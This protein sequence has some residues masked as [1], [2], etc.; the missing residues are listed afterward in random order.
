VLPTDTVYGVGARRRLGRGRAA[1][2]GR[3]A[4]RPR[5]PAAGAR[6]RG[7]RWC[8][9][10][11][12]ASTSASTRS[13]RGL[14]ARAADPRAAARETLRMDLGERG[15]HHRG[16]GPRPRLHPRAAAP[17]R[18][19]GGEQRQRARA[20]RRAHDRRTPSPSWGTRAPSTWTRG[21]DGGPGA[22][23]DRRPDR[24]LGPASC[25]RAGSPSAQLNEAVP[26]LLEIPDP[27]HRRGRVHRAEAGR[28]RCHRPETV[29]RSRTRASGRPARRRRVGPRSRGS[30]SRAEPVREYLLVLL[31]AAGV[32]YVGAS[33]ARR[34]AFRS[35]RSRSCAT[36]T[37]TPTPIPYF[38]GVA[39][40]AGTHR[41]LMVATNLP[42]LG[43]FELVQR[44]AWAVFWAPS[45]ICTV[46]VARRPVRAGG[47]G[48]VRRPGAGRGH[49]G[50]QR[51]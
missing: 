1:P 18:P 14:L 40:L 47:A 33:L 29:P 19:A 38:G 43:R 25:A 49:R 3:Q 42:W 26:G 46:G 37:C 24:P 21:P 7:R 23:H 16:A 34:L 15:E 36:A 51:A 48:Q 13:G 30:R 32:T 39:M 11:R 35:T 6:R 44:D 5:L 45:L 4:A 12:P 20:R 50:A 8:A 27:A 31:I 17:H 2:A 28:R 10:W 22:V 9:R 41:G